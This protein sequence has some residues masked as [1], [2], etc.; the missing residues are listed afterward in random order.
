MAT[1]LSLQGHVPPLNALTRQTHFEHFVQLAFVDGISKEFNLLENDFIASLDYLKDF[2]NN[3]YDRLMANEASIVI[4]NKN[5]ME[6]FNNYLP[7]LML[8]KF[9][10]NIC[11]MEKLVKND[12]KSGME[13]RVEVELHVLMQE[14]KQLCQGKDQHTQLCNI[15]FSTCPLLRHHI[16]MTNNYSMLVTMWYN[17]VMDLL[18]VPTN[19]LHQLVV[20]INCMLEDGSLLE[21]TWSRGKNGERVLLGVASRLRRGL[22]R[23]ALEAFVSGPIKEYVEEC[24]GGDEEVQMMAL[25]QEYTSQ[26]LRGLSAFF[27]NRFIHYN[28]L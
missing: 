22:S 15:L 12:C 7:N 9:K 19:L 24:S 26:L 28:V 21:N 20:K 10:G 3:F 25:I 27:N 14:L 8:S 16:L 13:R 6:A 4:H 1:V 5:D 23:Q 11:I 2:N 17:D 18:P